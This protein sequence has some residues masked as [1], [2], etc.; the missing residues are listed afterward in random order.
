VVLETFFT[1]IKAN[2][3][4][5]KRCTKIWYRDESIGFIILLEKG[6]YCRV[7]EKPEHTDPLKSELF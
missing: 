6:E 5:L 4:T 1:P 7:L 2:F 3:H